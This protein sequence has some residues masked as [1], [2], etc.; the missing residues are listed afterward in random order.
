MGR[1]RLL[2]TPVSGCSRILVATVPCEAEL[3]RPGR[4]STAAEVEDA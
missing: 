4:I 1:R 3:S 2:L